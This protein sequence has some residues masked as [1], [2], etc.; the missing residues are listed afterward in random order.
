M[1]TILALT[2]GS[3]TDATVFGTAVT[4]ARPLDAHLEFLHL[5]LSP[6]EA[7]AFTP[8]MDFAQG[9][10]LRAALDHLKVEAEK[11]SAASARHFRQFCAQ[12]AI[13]IS[14]MPMG[15]R[16]LSAVWHEVEGDS[17]DRL[18]LRVRHSDLTILARSAHANG[19][20]PDL[21]ERLLVG[22]GRPMLIA[23]ARPRPSMTGTALIC[24]NETSAAARAL[25]AALPLLAKSDRV[26][27]VG[28]ED[29]NRA[30]ID[31][32]R[33]LAQQLAW[34]RVRAEVK[35]VGANGGSAAEHL[36]A[37][38]ND[39]DADLLV[40]GGY[41]HSRARETILGGCTR[42]FLDHADRPV[43]MMH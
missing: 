8:H 31:G 14:D 9:A 43:F 37:V 33:D 3:E 4:V 34:H 29:S 26:V 6:G 11:R 21:I 23:P 22:C 39:Y 32:L 5:R 10:A 41:S 20:P 2:G 42:Y 12:E 15:S 28:A 1:K 36:T 24:W 16:G 30:T 17:L 13:E 27:I 19:M 18:A 40:M 7:A 35:W 25:A 38:A